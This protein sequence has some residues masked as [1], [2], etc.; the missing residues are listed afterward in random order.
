MAN[1]CTIA[2]WQFPGQDG[3]PS[4]ARTAANDTAEGTYSRVACPADLEGRTVSERPGVKLRTALF[5]RNPRQRRPRSAKL[6]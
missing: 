1:S 5:A 2:P 4:A 6:H 3:A